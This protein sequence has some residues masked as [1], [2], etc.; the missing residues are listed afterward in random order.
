[1]QEHLIKI[2]SRFS[3]RRDLISRLFIN[4]DTF[5]FRDD[6]SEEDKWGYYS[7]ICKELKV[8]DRIIRTHGMDSGLASSKKVGGH[9]E[10][11][12]F[13][14]FGLEVMSGTNKTDLLKE[15]ESFASLKGGKKIQWGMHVIDQLPKRF[16]ELFRDWILTYEKNSLYFN[17]RTE[18]AE[19]I[20]EKLNNKETLKD[21][22]NYYFRKCENVPFLIV[23][24]VKDGIYYRI[25]YLEFIDVL[26]D[27]IEFYTTKDKVKINAKIDIGEGKY[28]VIFEIEPRSDKDNA[29]LMHGLSD[30]IIK[31]INYYKIDV[32]ET[33]Q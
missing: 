16:I 18:F 28:R 5:E 3:M 7:F 27:N 22:L 29:I 32:K 9:N 4:S 17:R 19:K 2:L 23:K 14:K 33:Y 31:M 24:D 6:V 26:V 1:M 15:G 25:D 21:F 10:E 30:R 11:D 12:F 8:K 20:I 13:K